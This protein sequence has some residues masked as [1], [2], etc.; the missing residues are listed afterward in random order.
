MSG[1]RA[2]PALRMAARRLL[3]VVPVVLFILVVNYAL[4]R[5]APGDLVDVI[6]GEAGAA[7]PEYMEELRRR[8]SLDQPAL[9]HFLTYMKA[10]LSLD[11]GYSFRHGMPVA[12]LILDRLPATLLLT[13]SGI[14]F[15][16]VSGVFLGVLSARF[17]GRAADAAIAVLSTLGFATPVFWIGLMA[18]VVFSIQLRWLPAGGMVTVG[19]GHAGLDHLLDVARHLVLPAMTLGCFFTA[20]YCRITRAAM[21]EVQG[22][23]FVRTARAKGL[24]ERRI[25]LAHVLR[26]ALLPVVTLTGVQLG[27]LIGGSVVVETVFAWPGLGRLAF[28]AIF[29]RDMNLLLGILLCS[30]LLVILMNLLVDLLYAALDPRIEVR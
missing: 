3:Q 24:G 26:N 22:L 21:L 4:L 5:L 29:R 18:I 28:D 30:S 17:H 16:L 9:V 2:T 6:A 7:T 23:D 12:Q 8:F 20:Y 1:R 10:V 11:L 14:L 19:A 27:S 15:A 13:A 25:L